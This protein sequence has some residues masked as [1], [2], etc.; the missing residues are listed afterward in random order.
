MLRRPGI[1]SQ[2]IAVALAFGVA[3]A[4]SRAL[5]EMTKTRLQ[6][7]VFIVVAMVF[8]MVGRRAIGQRASIRG[9]ALNCIAIVIA[10]ISVKI[11]LEGPPHTAHWIRFFE[12]MLE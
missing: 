3:A 5:L 1:H 2:S 8:E 7:C 4:I 10:M 6:I 9:F 11:A 12:S